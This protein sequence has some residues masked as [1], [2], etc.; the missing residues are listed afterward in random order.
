MMIKEDIQTPLEALTHLRATGLNSPCENRSQL[1]QTNKNSNLVLA[2][3]GSFDFWKLL[4]LDGD[5]FTETILSKA[6]GVEE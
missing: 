3:H 4:Q 6:T 2:E 5:A 1:K